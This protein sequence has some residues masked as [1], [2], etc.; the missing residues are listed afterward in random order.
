V[1]AKLEGLGVS[2]VGN[3]PGD[4]ADIIK[5]ELPQWAKVIKRAGIKPSE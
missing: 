2:L 3:T 5:T 1:K 4:C